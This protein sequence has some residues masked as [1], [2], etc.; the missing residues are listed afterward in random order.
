[1][2]RLADELP[3]PPSKGGAQADQVLTALQD[4]VPLLFIEVDNCH[5]TPEELADKLERSTPG[6]SGGR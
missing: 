4:G 1:M 5:E 2:T 3:A 6:S